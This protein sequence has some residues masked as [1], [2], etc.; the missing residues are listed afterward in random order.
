MRGKRVLLFL[1]FITL[2]YP[3][4]ALPETSFELASP[5][6]RQVV[7]YTQYG[8]FKNVD[9]ENYVYEVRDADGLARASGEGVPPD[10]SILEDLAFK[11]YYSEHPHED[12]WKHRNGSPQ[13]DLF[14]WSQASG[15]D[16]GARLFYTAEA[17]RRGGHIVQALKAY[18]AIVVLYPKAIVWAADHGF[19][20]YVAPEAI[21]R[22]RKLCAT[23]PELGFQ[24]EGAFVDVRRGID[25][26]P[27]SDRVRTRPGAFVKTPV[28][29][30]GP[31][32]FD[33]VEERGKGKVRL[34]RYKNGDWRM[35]VDGKP[36]V[37]K[38]VTYS[39]TTVGE[40]AHALNLR[41][42]FKLDDNKNGKNDGMFDSWIDENRDGV[43]QNAVE[44]V[45]GDA[46]LLQR[47]GANA[48]R[49]Y[50]GVD[51]WGK[52]QPEEYDK[53]LMRT[54]QKEYGVYF[55]LGD[56]VGAYTV[57]SQ[58]R[59]DIGTDYTDAAE[60]RS[61][62]DSVRA[63]VMDH[64]DEPYV[65][66][67]LL[68]NEN[69]HPNTHTQ[70]Y[71]DPE[72]YARFLNE[73]AKMI[74]QIDP[75]HP[76]AVCNLNFQNL[77]EL[78]KLAPQIDIY[79]ANIYSGAYAMG[80]VWHLAK[81]YYG[82]P[83][84]ITEFGCDAYAQG[85]GPDEEAQ[86]DYFRQNWEDIALNMSGNRGEGNAIG[87]VV[88]EWMDEWWKSARGDAWGD[89]FVH[90]AESDTM[91]PFPDSWANEEWLGVMGQGDGKESHFLRE[92]RKVYD[93]IARMWNGRDFD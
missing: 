35:L 68:G 79:G 88:F 83:V 60:I 69:Q 72:A 2:A 80:S 44:P 40:S 12:P 5:G 20:W 90:N 17:L 78:G 30:A 77:A 75:D 10:A 87:G 14:A 92:K 3:V 63:M 54:L 8:E 21:Y 29:K 47:M 71:E 28:H 4:H 86:A 93:E 55:I 73:A 7:D 62:L 31:A 57:G 24:L 85:R 42:W 23:Y 41:P 33:I 26:K 36:F 38:G 84:L 16:D 39:C 13:E 59:W 32:E 58:A 15:M 56:F 61:M 43:Q 45:V 82:R 70:A 22:A 66:M 11:I 46:A 9:T 50:H 64:K 51:A 6:S 18:H 1:L 27:G 76:V 19:Y 34:A 81:E 89:P 67:W 52:Y 53:E 49:V 25:G 91:N 74:H 37:V 48:I 65:L